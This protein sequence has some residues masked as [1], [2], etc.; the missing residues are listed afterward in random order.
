MSRAAES[1]TA[2]AIVGMS[3]RFPGAG[4]LDQFWANLSGGV[5]SIR[6]FTPEELAAS[7]LDPISQSNPQFVNAGAPLDDAEMFDAS[8]FGF[9]ARE[10]E[11]MDPQ[12]R[13]FLECAWHALEDAAHTGAVDIPI[14]IFAGMSTSTY[15]YLLYA[16]PEIV[17]A[18]G[19]NRSERCSPRVM[20]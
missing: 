3:G 12:R 14:G 16:H 13:V 5:E 4:D 17:A 7:G 10:A 19:S 6:A 2:I 15:L 9:N 18:V 20:G 11:S 1:A 8:F